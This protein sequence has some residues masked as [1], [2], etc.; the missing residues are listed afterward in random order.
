M[1]EIIGSAS[2]LHMG[3]IISLYAEGSVAGFLS[4]LGWVLN[5]CPWNGSEQT[6]RNCETEWPSKINW[7]YHPHYSSTILLFDVQTAKLLLQRP[8]KSRKGL[9][10][11]S[12]EQSWSNLIIRT[13]LLSTLV[14]FATMEFF[15]F[16]GQGLTVMTMD[17]HLM[18]WHVH[19]RSFWKES[20]MLLVRDTQMWR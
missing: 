8:D 13:F 5:V 2:F 16:V 14:T 3:D 11:L 19:Q 15:S 1:G 7:C 9:G 18:T 4:T 17:W 6:R 12:T 20:S 10:N